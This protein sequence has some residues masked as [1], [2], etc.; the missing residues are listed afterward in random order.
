MLQ[1]SEIIDKLSG[2]ALA[3]QVATEITGE[4]QPQKVQANIE[5]NPGSKENKLVQDSRQRAAES[6]MP[7]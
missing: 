4:A 2:T 7:Q 5:A 3:D 1:A 6:T